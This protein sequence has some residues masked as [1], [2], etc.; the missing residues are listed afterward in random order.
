M[1]TPYL[2]LR[3]GLFCQMW[4]DMNI[5]HAIITPYVNGVNYKGRCLYCG[6]SIRFGDFIKQNGWVIGS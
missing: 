4:L 2:T 6:N 1:L 3:Q 5:F